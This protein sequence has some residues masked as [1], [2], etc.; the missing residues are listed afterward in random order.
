MSALARSDEVATAYLPNPRSVQRAQTL[1][2]AVEAVSRNIHPHR[3]K[4]GDP[5]RSGM[6]CITSTLDLGECALGY[7]QYG[8]DVMIDPGVISDFLLVKSTLSGQGQVTCGS[9]TATT[10]PSSI[11]MTS[12]SERTGIVMSAH[13]R[14]LTARVARRAIEERLERRLGRRL[15]A[16]LQF[17]LQSPATSDFGRAWHQ[18]LSHICDLSAHAPGVLA[19]ADV[20]QQYSS[21]MIELLV[22]TARHNYSDALERSAQPA[23]PRHVRRAREYMHEHLPDLRSIAEVAAWI[24]VTPRTLQNGFRQ[25]FNLTPAQYLRELRIMALHQALRG[26]APGRTV[27]DLMQSVGIVNFSRYAQYYRSRLG[28]SPSATLRN[29]P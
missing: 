29:G 17:D 14:H 2:G 28:V 1:D 16:P 7:V 5:R 21:T 23:I 10:A 3:L 8:F 27:G 20:R 12:M 15:A 6:A 19:S 11:V 13:C 22:H 4:L 26:A 25:A 18:L 9:L 24:G